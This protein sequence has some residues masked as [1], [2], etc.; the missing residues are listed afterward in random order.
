MYLA[1]LSLCMLLC[2]S[3]SG[4]ILPMKKPDGSTDASS[5]LSHV[6]LLEQTVTTLQ[7]TTGQLQTDIQV[8]KA[9]SAVQIASLTK[10]VDALKAEL[11]ISSNDVAVLKSEMD[12]MKRVYGN[13]NNQ[14]NLTILDRISHDVK[15][16]SAQVNTF[17]TDIKMLDKQFNLIN[18]TVGDVKKDT[19]RCIQNTSS[20]IQLITQKEAELQLTKTLAQS[21]SQHLK[22]LE[23]EQNSTSAS[24]LLTQNNLILTSSEVTTLRGDLSAVKTQT[25]DNKQSLVKVSQDLKMVLADVHTTTNTSLATLAADLAAVKKQSEDSKKLVTAL[26]SKTRDVAFQVSN[27]TNRAPAFTA[28]TFNKTRYNAGSAFNTST[29]KFSA[30]ESGTYM[31]WTKLEMV[32]TNTYMNVYIM[33]SGRVPMAGGYVATDANIYVADGSAVAVDH[34]SKGEEVWVE[35]SSR[36]NLYDGNKSSYF[37]GVMLSVD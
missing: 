12:H 5:L 33:K 32:E 20:A 3:L 37:G 4:L 16:N 18:A 17:Q 22:K 11:K 15:M 28:L 21:A 2:G 34:L 35:V 27:P 6:T 23:L 8:S 31:F 30:P 7:T 9:Q 25:R 36:H 29:G 19:D 1:V 10:E 13:M 24:L 26:A 14:L